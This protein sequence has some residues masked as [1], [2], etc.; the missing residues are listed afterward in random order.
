MVLLC[1]II[2]G[3]VDVV[4]LPNAQELRASDVFTVE[5]NAWLLCPFGGWALQVIR[6][7]D[8]A[9]F[10]GAGCGVVLCLVRILPHLTSHLLVVWV[11]VVVAVSGG[12]ATPIVGFTCMLHA[13]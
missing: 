7:Q 3:S 10:V 13:E 8:V 11:V 1:L 6:A 2:N 12:I 9:C 4:A 5:G